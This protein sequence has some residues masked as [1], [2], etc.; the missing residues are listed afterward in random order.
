MVSAAMTLGTLSDEELA[1]RAVAGDRAAASD[2]VA[3]TYPAVYGLARRMTGADDAARDAAQ[4]TFLRAFRHL[5]TYSAE[6]RFTAWIFRILANHLRDLARRPARQVEA[7]PE[8]LASDGVGPLDLVLRAEDLGRAA[9][10]VDRL[11]AEDRLALLLT[12]GQGLNA[13]EAAHVLGCSH[14]AM[15]LRISRAVRRLREEVA[16][17]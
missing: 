3:R 14:A 9:A 17:R 10:A 2:L 13:R 15:R 5:A 6:F 11:G 4:E 7:E 16:G 1:R 12:Y 8:A